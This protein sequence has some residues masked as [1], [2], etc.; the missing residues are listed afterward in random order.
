MDDIVFTLTN[1][2]YLITR[3]TFKLIQ[4]FKQDIQPSKDHIIEFITV[5][6]FGN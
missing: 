3:M 5:K 6:F 4:S 2:R 1:H